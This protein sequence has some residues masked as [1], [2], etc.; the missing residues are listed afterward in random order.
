MKKHNRLE[1]KTSSFNGYHRL[2][3]FNITK[4]IVDRAYRHDNE[5]FQEKYSV[6]DPKKTT[7]DNNNNNKN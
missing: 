5:I 7:T 6:A 4:L 1:S 2:T 3:S